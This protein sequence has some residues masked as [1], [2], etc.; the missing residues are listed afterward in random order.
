M[1][2][3]FVCLGELIVDKFTYNYCSLPY[4][5]VRYGCSSDASYVH[6]GSHAAGK[7]TACFTSDDK[8]LISAGATDGTLIIWSVV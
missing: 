3:P 8:Y 5:Y 1:T 7:V 4:M 6:V 2:D